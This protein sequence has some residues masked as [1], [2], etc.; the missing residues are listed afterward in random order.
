ML[1]YD[2]YMKK[3]IIQMYF[4]V[5]VR[6]HGRISSEFCELWPKYNNLTLPMCVSLLKLFMLFKKA[7][8]NRN[9]NSESKIN[10]WDQLK[11][12]FYFWN[13]T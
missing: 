5:T 12:S 8:L 2:M 13:L 9:E 10:L 11:F 4:L 3:L 6:R 1:K 7:M